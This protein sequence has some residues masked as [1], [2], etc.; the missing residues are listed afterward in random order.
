MEYDN[1][2]ASL[3]GENEVLRIHVAATSKDCV[4]PDLYEFIYS[5]EELVR[6]GYLLEAIPKPVRNEAISIAMQSEEVMGFLTSKT[7]P[8]V[9]R[10]LPE[11]ATK[12]HSHKTLV[13]VTWIDGAVSALVDM[14]TGN[15]VQVWK[16]N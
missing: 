4:Y 7:E 11:T 14:D 8:S 2:T 9:K 13:S 5:D 3:S 1:V 12:F 16:G 6:V 15:V 10:I